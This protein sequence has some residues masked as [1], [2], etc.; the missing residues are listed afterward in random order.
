MGGDEVNV[1]KGLRMGLRSMGVGGMEASRLL[2][3]R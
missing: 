1:A 2:E 3:R